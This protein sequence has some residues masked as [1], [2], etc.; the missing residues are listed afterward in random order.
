MSTPKKAFL[1]EKGN[2]RLGVEES[3][4]YRILRLRGIEVE[5]FTEKRIRRRQLDLARDVLVAGSIPVV[6][7]AL[8]QLGV[9]PPEPNDY[10]RCLARHLHRRV[11]TSTI[12]QVTAIILNDELHPVFVKPIG[13]MKRFTGAVVHT[14]DELWRFQGA[15]LRLPVFCSEPVDWLTEHRAYVASGKIVGIKH[16]LGDPDV[17]LDED[18]VAAAVAELEN[19]N[20]AVAGYALDF[21]V[22][23][24]GVTALVEMNDGFSLGSYDLDPSAYTDLITARW[25]E[26]TGSARKTG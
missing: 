23:S 26:I 5:L 19:S 20:E 21:G 17:E 13:R 9:E 3:D 25:M 2:G 12:R 8:R 10:P 22:L 4:L 18:V 16:Y 14:R 7:G 15:S 11:W 1:Q 24:T 6:L